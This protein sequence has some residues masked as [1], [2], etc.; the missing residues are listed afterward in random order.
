LSQED[1][2]CYERISM[3]FQPRDCRGVLKHN[4]RRRRKILN[5]L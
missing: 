4:I 1:F 3:S 5:K 2:A